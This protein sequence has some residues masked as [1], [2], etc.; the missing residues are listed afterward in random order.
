MFQQLVQQP[1]MPQQLGMP[2]PM[3]GM[4]PPKSGFMPMPGFGGQGGTTIA[5]G[6]LQGGPQ[7]RQQPS[8][9]PGMQGP[10]LGF[11]GSFPGGPFAGLMQ[12]LQG[13][14][15][16]QGFGFQGQMNPPGPAPNPNLALNR[17]AGPFGNGGG[18][19]APGFQGGFASPWQPRNQWY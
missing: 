4:F 9:P 14:Q 12:M 1:G 8:I 2:G 13:M 18:P 15:Q 10:G 5:P 19:I 6:G 11:Q 3:P 7:F 16:G 17:F